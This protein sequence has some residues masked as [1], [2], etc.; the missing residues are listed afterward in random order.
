MSAPTEAV[1][2][3]TTAGTPPRRGLGARLRALTEDPNL[4]LGLNTYQGKT[5]HEAV[6]E[7]LELEYTPALELLG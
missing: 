5:T 4:R 6:A 3:P 7:S 2:Q 1:T